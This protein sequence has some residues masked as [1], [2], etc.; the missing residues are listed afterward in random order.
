MGILIGWG[1]ATVGSVQLQEFR[2]IIDVKAGLSFEFERNIH[3]L[4]K[5]LH[6]NTLGKLLQC[7]SSYMVQ[8]AEDECKVMTCHI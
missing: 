7:T 3:I 4:P 1:R 5:V 2:Y 8:S 6:D